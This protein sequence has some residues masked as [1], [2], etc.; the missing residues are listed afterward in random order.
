MLKGCACESAV[1][2]AGA[3]RFWVGGNWKMNGSKE[4]L[5]ALM[6]VWAKA[7]LKADAGWGERERVCVCVC[8]CQRE[9]KE[10]RDERVS[11]WSL[12]SPFARWD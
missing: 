4:S 11:S 6:D 8:V 2:T 1:A 9:R 12:L 5:G 3:R 7:D 10:K